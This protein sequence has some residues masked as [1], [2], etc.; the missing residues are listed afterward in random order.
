MVVLSWIRPTTLSWLRPTAY[1]TPKIPTKYTLGKGIN[2]SWS[3]PTLIPTKYTLPDKITLSWIRPNALLW[4]KPAPYTAVSV[5]TGYT[6]TKDGVQISGQPVAGTVIAPGDSVLVTKFPAPSIPTEYVMTKDGIAIA[7]TPATTVA[8]AT[9]TVP[10]E[11][12]DTGGVA[13]LYIP[14]YGGGTVT[15]TVRELTT[16]NPIRGASAELLGATTY[17]FPPTGDD[18]VSKCVEVDAGSYSIRV[19]ASGYKDEV[20]SLTVTGGKDTPI[21]LRLEL[22]AAKLFR[23]SKCGAEFDNYEALAKH[24]RDVHG[25]IEFPPIDISPS[26]YLLIAAALIVYVVLRKVK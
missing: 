1:S 13:A 15:L 3:G 22:A 26:V 11:K 5:P 4:L 25:T 14:S 2:L 21:E 19:A 8:P 12:M 20:T 9:E 17:A 16:G 23:C 6:M 7:P 24:E 10:L 18:G